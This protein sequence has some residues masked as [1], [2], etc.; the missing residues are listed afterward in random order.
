MLGL[1]AYDELQ[2]FRDFVKEFD[3]RGKKIL[4]IG[5]SI[6]EIELST[7]ELDKWVSVDPLNEEKRDLNNCYIYHKRDAIDIPYEADYFDFVFSSNAFE[8]IQKLDQ[9]LEELYRVLKKGGIIYSHFGPIWSGPDGHHL[10]DVRLEHNILNFWE[11]NSLPHYSHL[12]HTEEQLMNLLTDVYS[13]ND[14]RSISQ[15]V[16]HSPWL[17]RLTYNDYMRIF[18]NSRFIIRHLETTSEVDYPF[19][20]P[21]YKR[22]TSSYYQDLIHQFP[23]EDFE[24]RDI[25]VILKK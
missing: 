19:Q 23:A 16:Y 24:V 20:P 6:P 3:I 13:I 12:V 10:E 9:V 15:F 2:V 8:H 21:T 7:F 18:G 1:I 17:N 25:L 22:N 4:E 5:G 14:A 11:N